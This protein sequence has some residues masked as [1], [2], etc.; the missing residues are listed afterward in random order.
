MFENLIKEVIRLLVLISTTCF[1]SLTKLHAVAMQ[2]GT[3]GS[4][5]ATSIQQA[6][7]IFFILFFRGVSVHF[8]MCI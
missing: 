3:R 5:A 6:F 2:L 1:N 8:G 7:S 4:Y